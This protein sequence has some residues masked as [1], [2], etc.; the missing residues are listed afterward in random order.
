MKPIFNKDNIFES[1]LDKINQTFGPANTGT[2]GG[3]SD[4]L[5]QYKADYP[6]GGTGFGNMGTGTSETKGCTRWTSLVG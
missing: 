3:E 5:K 6:A 1:T 4:L 2:G